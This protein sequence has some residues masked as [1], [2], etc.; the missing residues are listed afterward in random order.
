M[1]DI[2]AA[3]Q[4][5]LR[6]SGFNRL[7]R[8]A[9]PL[10]WEVERQWPTGAAAELGADMH[11][12]V[13]AQRLAAAHGLAPPVLAFDPSAR[14]LRMPWVEG[15]PLDPAWPTSPA[16]RAAMAALLGRLRALPAPGL[17]TLDLPGRILALH[18]RLAARD[19]PRAALLADEV[20]A[21]LALWDSVAAPDVGPDS[22]HAPRCLVHG[23]LTS[24]NILLR[25]DGTVLL[26]DWE[27]AHAGGPWDD[28]AGLCA[29]FDAIGG[30]PL[31]DWVAAVPAV[32]RP[33]FDAARRARRLLDTLWYA[34]ADWHLSRREGTLSPLS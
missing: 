16:Q 8:I 19:A 1:N 32:V 20:G 24:A 31:D 23:D 11:A 18:R 13:A 12:E 33:R 10:G 7:R 3:E 21:A 5:S 15:L 27:Y 22:P 17:P 34:L 30:A 2:P 28:L 9:T 6:G 29:T 26:L 4:P 25:D 14:T